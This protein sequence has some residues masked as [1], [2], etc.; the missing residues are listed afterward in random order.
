LASGVLSLLLLGPAD[1]VWWRCLG[2][3][4]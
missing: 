1:Y 2:A 4:A 3:I